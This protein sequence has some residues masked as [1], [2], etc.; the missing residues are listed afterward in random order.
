MLLRYLFGRP[1]TIFVIIAFATSKE[2]QNALSKS[3]EWYRFRRD[4]GDA[5]VFTV[6]EIGSR[7]ASIG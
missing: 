4:A 5:A 6:V 2:L 3:K 7:F 1:A